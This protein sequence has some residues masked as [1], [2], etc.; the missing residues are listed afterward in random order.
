MHKSIAYRYD[1]DDCRALVV[2]GRRD[3][4][5]MSWYNQMY[6]EPPFYDVTQSI[7][8]FSFRGEVFTLFHWVDDRVLEA[9]TPKEEGPSITSD[10]ARQHQSAEA[11]YNVVRWYQEFRDAMDRFCFA[12]FLP[13]VVEG[14]S[15]DDEKEPR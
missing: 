12:L 13:P 10:W 2:H 7:T 9:V 4:N 14:D 5:E 15:G 6:P 1:G 11:F 3:A 8:R